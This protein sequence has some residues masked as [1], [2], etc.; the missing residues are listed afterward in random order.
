[1]ARKLCV[2]LFVFCF[3]PTWV[4]YSDYLWPKLNRLRTNTCKYSRICSLQTTVD[5]I[6]PFEYQSKTATAI[7][8]VLSPVSSK[9]Q[10]N[11][12]DGAVC[13]PPLRSKAV[14]NCAPLLLSALV[15]RSDTKTYGS[16]QICVESSTDSVEFY[17]YCCLITSLYTIYTLHFL[18]FPE[19]R[20][21]S[22]YVQSRVSALFRVTD[23]Q[24]LCAVRL[25]LNSLKTSRCGPLF[26]P[27]F[28]PGGKDTD[29]SMMKDLMS[30]ECGLARFQQKTRDAR[31]FSLKLLTHCT[32]SLFPEKTHPS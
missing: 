21:S 17:T 8:N 7:P 26:L 3:S 14:T 27:R 11:K 18:S 24:T 28:L 25:L 12:A 22:A 6:T 2:A 31:A 16:Y 4:F 1:M 20:E 5:C 30:V 29:R 13:V 32:F 23:A 15:S 9:V 10:I 19:R